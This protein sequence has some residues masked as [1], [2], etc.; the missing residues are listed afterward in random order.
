[1]VLLLAASSTFASDIKKVTG[2][3]TYFTPETMSIEKA[4]REVNH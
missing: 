3:Y 1:M 4:K 2:T